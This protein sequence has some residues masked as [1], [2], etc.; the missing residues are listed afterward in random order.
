[1][2]GGNEKPVEQHPLDRCVVVGA[3]SP[4]ERK[5]GPP[6]RVTKPQALQDAA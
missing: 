4:G 5:S 2:G 1:M 3:V 6:D